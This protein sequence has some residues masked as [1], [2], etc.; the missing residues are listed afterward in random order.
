MGAGWGLDG[1][2]QG[3]QGPASR[4]CPTPTPTL[5]LV[6]RPQE[7]ECWQR[8][9]QLVT[10]TEK[11]KGVPTPGRGHRH[12]ALGCAAHPKYPSHNQA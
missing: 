6:F 12:V 1:G 11:K 4:A 5:C 3:N 2:R 7:W 8:V 10:G 9:N